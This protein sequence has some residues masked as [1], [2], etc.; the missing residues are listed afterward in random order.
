MIEK[1]ATASARKKR[2]SRLT[3]FVIQIDANRLIT[4]K[5]SETMVSTDPRGR[6][7]NLKHNCEDAYENGLEQR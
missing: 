3:F 6:N 1:C 2:S 5:N 7:G 4:G